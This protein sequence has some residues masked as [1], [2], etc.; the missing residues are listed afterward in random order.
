MLEIE[1]TEES[2]E[3]KDVIET[4]DD[5]DD[6]QTSLQRASIYCTPMIG[7]RSS[8]Y[9]L[10]GNTRR[11]NSHDSKGN[12]RRPSFYSLNDNTEINI[13]EQLL[14]EADF[15]AKAFPRRAFPAYVADTLSEHV[16]R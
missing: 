12:S 10:M 5:I 3:I 6:I 16:Q 9:K 14:L 4:E 2:S 8:P 7:R 1:Q 15:F 11:P 13:H